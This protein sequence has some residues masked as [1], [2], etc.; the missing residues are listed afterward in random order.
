MKGRKPKPP[1]LR[2]GHRSPPVAPRFSPLMRLPE[3][4][5]DLNEAGKE[6][7]RVVGGR[8]IDARAMDTAYLP[9][10]RLF[11]EACHL[12]DE[13]WQ[14]VQESSVVRPAR[15]RGANPAI[16][17]WRDCV[18]TGRA[19]GEQLGASPVALARLGLAHVRGMS[20]AQELALAQDERERKD[21]RK[22]R[23]KR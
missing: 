21:N 20:M 5:S 11:A 13:A 10:L 7:S 16:R 3:P 14:E 17:V 22:G 9:L 15:E 18:A 19:L 8:L 6:A 1:H 23:P 2:E 12:A 4:P